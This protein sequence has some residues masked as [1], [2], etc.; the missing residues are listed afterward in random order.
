M[1]VRVFLFN[2]TNSYY[3]SDPLITSQLL[4][5]IN[6]FITV[7][8]IDNDKIKVENILRWLFPIF[9]V[10]SQKSKEAIMNKNTESD[11]SILWSGVLL[12]LDSFS[13]LIDAEEA[14]KLFLKLNP[15]PELVCK[16]YSSIFYLA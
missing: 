10:F 1:Y 9:E 14:K 5:E 13:K 8:I 6:E 11:I 2:L 12:I 7:G 3:I 16:Y 15:I 4:K